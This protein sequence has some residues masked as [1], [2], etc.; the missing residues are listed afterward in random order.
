MEG[1]VAGFLVRASAKMHRRTLLEE[2]LR[3]SY[4]RVNLT[5]TGHKASQSGCL[6]FLTNLKIN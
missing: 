5:L 4:S 6:L 3:M 1:E 2:G